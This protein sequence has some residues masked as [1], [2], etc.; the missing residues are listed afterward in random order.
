MLKR[1]SGPAEF[2]AA[3]RDNILPK[4]RAFCPDLILVSAGFDAHSEDPIGGLK[5]KD[6]DYGIVQEEIMKVALECCHGRVVSVLEGGYN[7]EAIARA[8]VHC[9]RAQVRKVRGKNSFLILTVSWRLRTAH[10]KR[11]KLT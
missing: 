8:A 4:L 7:V 11:T 3:W 2:H 5:L 9:V 10:L 1:R 6:E